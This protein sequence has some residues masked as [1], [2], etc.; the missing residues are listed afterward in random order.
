LF[1]QLN[2]NNITYYVALLELIGLSTFKRQE[3]RHFCSW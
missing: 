3:K 1:K 2:A